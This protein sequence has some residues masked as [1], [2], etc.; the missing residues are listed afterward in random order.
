MKVG[1]KDVEKEFLKSDQNDD[2]TLSEGELVPTIR[3]YLKRF[4]YA[5]SDE[6]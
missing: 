6:L 3:R 4:K 5:A 1:K 2:G